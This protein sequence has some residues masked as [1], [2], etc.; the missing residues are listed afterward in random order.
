[1]EKLSFV[2]YISWV[3]ACPFACWAHIPLLPFLSAVCAFQA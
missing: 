3:H 2:L 1:M